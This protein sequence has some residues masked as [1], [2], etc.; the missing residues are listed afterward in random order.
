MLVFM[1]IILIVLLLFYYI[2]LESNIIVLLSVSIILIIHNLISR[3]YFSTTVDEQIQITDTQINNLINMAQSLQNTAV[4]NTNVRY[5]SIP[6]I[7]SCP[8]GDESQFNI[9]EN[10]SSNGLSR[11]STNNENQGISEIRPSDLPL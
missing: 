5:D 7:N 4:E 1:F 10:G 8:I 11:L 2:D 6:I 9:N 3:E